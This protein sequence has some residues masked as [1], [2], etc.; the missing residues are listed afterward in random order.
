MT[1]E[2]FAEA[3]AAAT[4]TPG[5]GSASAQAGAMA[6]SLI[7]MM[8]DLTLGREQYR[9]HEQAV[10]GIRHRAEGLRKDL[11]ALVDRDAQ[12]YDAV[13]TARRLPKTTEAERE[14][15]SA[16]LDRAN[17]F[18][19]EAPMAIADA[20]TAL[21]GMASDLASRG[22]VNAVISVRV[23]LK[24]VKDEA[25]GAKIRD[26]VR[27]LEMDAEKLREEALTAI[28]LRTNGR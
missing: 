3:L 27:R 26:R 10:Q 20:C 24:G 15:R 25:R 11:L 22:N 12:A 18:A 21:M 28:Y 5:G 19:I 17:L 23:N 13:V 16:A 8:C 7:Q 1:V 6:A 4:P 14:A 9:A 2:Q